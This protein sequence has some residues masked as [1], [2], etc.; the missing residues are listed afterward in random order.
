MYDTMIPLMRCIVCHQELRVSSTQEAS[1][2]GEIVEGVVT[3]SAG[4]TWPIEE[5]ILVFTREDAPSD[6]WSKTYA[7]Y[8]K[9]CRYQETW[10]SEAAGQ[11]SPLLE[12]LVVGPTDRVLDL[13]TGSGGLLFNLLDHLDRESE[14]V[15]L[16][17]SL[18]VQRHNRRY[19]LDRYGDRR[20]SF[21][22]ADAA[23]VPFQ[24]HVLSHIV[25]FGMGNMLDKMALGVAEA[26]RILER[27]G[28]FTFTHSY[29]DEDSEGWHLLGAYMREQGV[30]D[31]GFL[32]IERDFLALVDRVGFREY[33]VQVTAEV[34]GE[35]GRD[36]EAGPLFPYPNERMTELLIRATQG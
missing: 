10:L 34:V 12:S 24:E 15:S 20:V 19:C 36:V 4:H 11:V 18:A 16:D 9:Y 30:E 29:V 17:M 26:A 23:D 6:P 14:V 7:E 31:F 21:V 33:Q 13:C 25:S 27:G 32:G 28:T 35:P 8:E 3:C 1:P 22:S 5:G 2:S